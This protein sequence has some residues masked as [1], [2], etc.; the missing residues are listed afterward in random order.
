MRQNGTLTT[1]QPTARL[2]DDPALERSSVVANNAMNRERGLAGANGYGRELGLGAL[3]EI[4]AAA[5][6]ARPASRWLDLCC[7]PV[8]ALAAERLAAGR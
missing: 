6:R 1:P 2:L 5:G 4:R 7:G 3:V 8:R